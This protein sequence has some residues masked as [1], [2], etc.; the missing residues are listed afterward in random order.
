MSPSWTVSLGRSAAPCRDRDPATSSPLRRRM[1]REESHSL[2]AMKRRG[3]WRSATGRGL[4]WRLRARSVPGTGTRMAGP[5]LS[6]SRNCFFR[7][8]SRYET[9]RPSQIG[10]APLLRDNPSIARLP[11]LRMVVR[12]LPQG[13]RWQ[14]DILGREAEEMQNAQDGAVQV[15]DHVL[16]G[17]IERHDGIIVKELRPV[18]VLRL[19]DAHER[20][21]FIEVEAW[22]AV[23]TGIVGDPA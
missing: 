17:Q 15:L 6:K 13:R 5:S 3:F 10:S 21:D 9:G 4:R 18:R 12:L 23:A 7:A 22:L 20:I 8:C 2:S 11:V 1:A 16:I 19:T 14:R